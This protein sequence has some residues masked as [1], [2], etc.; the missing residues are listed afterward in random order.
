MFSFNLF[1]KLLGLPLVFSS[2]FSNVHRIIS[3]FMQ[4]GTFQKIKTVKVS[5]SVT[6]AP[7]S[8]GYRFGITYVGSSMKLSET[9]VNKTNVHFGEIMRTIMM[10][11]RVT[12]ILT[13]RTY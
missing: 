7:V 10:I 3:I 6:L 5:H 12:S 1:N 13:M 4:H 9:E 8:S 11:T 2:Y